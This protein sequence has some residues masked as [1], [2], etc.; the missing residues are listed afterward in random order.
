MQQITA[1]C[2]VANGGY[3]VTPY[4][5][6]HIVDSQGNITYTHTTEIK[7]QVISKETAATVAAM[8]EEGVSGDGGAKNAAVVGYKIAAKTGTSEK[9]DILDENGNSYL[10]IGSCVGFAP[11]DNAEIAI[12][13]VVDEPTT[14][15]Y[16]S[17]V[18][19]PYVGDL[20]EVYLP[21]LGHENANEIASET[22]TVGTYTGLS[23]E[24]IQ[25]MLKK[26]G[27]A[28]EIVGDGETVTGQTPNSG[29]V[30]SVNVGRIILYAGKGADAYV[31]VPDFLNKS[32]SEANRI[33]VELG[34]NLA[35][36]GVDNYHIGVGAVVV[37]QS[38]APGTRVKKGTLV[39]LTFLYTDNQD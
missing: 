37:R 27:I 14:A 16:G 17:M 39:K 21:Y 15:K 34:L 31:T 32:P 5:V 12:L 6:E 20:M 22:F 3:L 24:Q 19:A 38:I 36:M 23:V 1:I 18:A 7:R 10:R 4:M 30:I 13:I 11:S 33:I 25:K 28:V 29:T 26:E 9:F 35:A 2:A 8:L